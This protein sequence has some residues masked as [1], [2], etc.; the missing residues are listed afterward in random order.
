M[1]LIGSRLK[2]ESKNRLKCFEITVVRA[3]QVFNQTRTKITMDK[4]FLSPIPVPAS[5]EDIDV[6]ANKV[7]LVITNKIT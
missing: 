6:L 2:A 1:V 7:H 3:E 4:R 5:T